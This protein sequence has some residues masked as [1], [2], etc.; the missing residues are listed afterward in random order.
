MLRLTLVLTIMGFVAQTCFA[1]LIDSSGGILSPTIIDFGQFAGANTA[2]FTSPVQVGDFVG[3]DVSVSSTNPDGSFLG[4]GPYNF[5]DNGS[6]SDALALA[7][8][9]IDLFGFDQYV[10]TFRFNDGP[11]AQV[12]GF[13]NYAL[14]DS[15]GFSD[16]VISALALDGSVLESYDIS[17]LDPIATPGQIDAGGFRGISRSS[18]DIFGFSLSNSAVAITDLTFSSEVAAVPEPKFGILLIFGLILGGLVRETCLL[19][20]K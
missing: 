10:M 14:F 8:L 17:Q 3:R 5:N 1:D 18:A 20:V 2:F 4:S 13:L 11:V 15:S 12:G 16:V 7:G 6:W 19:L 9:D